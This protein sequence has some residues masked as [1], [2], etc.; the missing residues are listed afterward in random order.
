[1]KPSILLVDDSLTVRMDL[2]EA[3]ESAGFRVVLCQTA[4]EARTALARQR[5]SLIVLD[6]ILP[7]GDGIYL[8]REIRNEATTAT[9][10]VMLLSTEA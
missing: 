6:V 9:V 2:R 7:D 10:P 4:A 5:F 8:L 3:F 1:M